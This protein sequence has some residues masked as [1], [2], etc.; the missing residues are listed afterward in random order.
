MC[1]KFMKNITLYQESGSLGILHALLDCRKDARGVSL[2][3]QAPS[4][5]FH[6]V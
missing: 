3:S 1:F 5:E 4:N 2:T 6:G